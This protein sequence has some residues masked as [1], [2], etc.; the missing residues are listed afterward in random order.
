MQ[1]VKN[2]VLQFEKLEEYYA[3]KDYAKSIDVAAKIL[4]L[5]PDFTHVKL[6]YIESLLQEVRLEEAEKFLLNKISADERSQNE[7]F[8]YLL[9][10]TY[11]FE[12]K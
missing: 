8:D 12:G 6:I 3:K 7:D 9:A 2:L 5:A 11:Y 10:K 1:D 4:G